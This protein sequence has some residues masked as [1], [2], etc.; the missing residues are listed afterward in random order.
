MDDLIITA[1]KARRPHTGVGILAQHPFVAIDLETTGVSADLN[2]IVEIG[3]VKMTPTGEVVETF[4][5]IV[6]PGAD[7][8]LPRSAERIHHIKPHQIRSAPPIDEVLVS[9][10]HFIGN[11]GVVAHQL[12]FENR[13][14]TA[15]YQRIGANLPA[16]QGLCTLSMARKFLNAK[17]NKLEYLLD[18]L[19]LDGVN[20]H[21]ATDDAYACGTFAAHMISGLNVSD[22]EPL[23]GPVNNSPEDGLA[24]AV[25][26]LK[27]TLG[28]VVISEP[29]HKEPDA[30]TVRSSKSPAPVSAP[31]P[32]GS[33]ASTDPSPQDGTSVELLSSPDVLKEAFGGFSPTD[34]QLSA[35]EAFTEGGTTKLVAVAGAGKTATLLGMARLEELRN[36]DRRG[37]YLAFNRSVAEEAKRKF[38]RTVTAM[39]AHKLAMTQLRN[40]PHG[41]LLAKLGER[42]PWRTTADAIYPA[43]TVVDMHDGR[44]LFSSY[45]IG[46]YALRTVEEFCKTLDTDIG[47]QHMPD[48][49]GITRGSIQ[50]QQLAEAVVP[51]AKRAWSNM[52]DPNS[53]AV[54][55][56]HSCY[57]KL[58]VDSHPR[59]GRDGDYI[60]LDEA[61]DSNPVVARLF[62]GQ[63]HLQR[64]LVGDSNQSIYGFT[65]A[66]DSLSKFDADTV[67]TLSQSWRFGDAIADA[68]NVYLRRLQ[69]PVLVRGNSRIDDAV[70]FSLRDTTAVL[71]RTNGGAI[72]EI[73]RTQTAG[74][75]AALVGDV[76]A[77]L[78]FC[79]AA[80]SLQNGNTPTN[81]QFAVFSTWGQLEEYIE[82]QPGMSDLGTQAKLVND[83][84]VDAIESAL[85]NLVSPA[86]ADRIFTTAHKSKGLEYPKVRIADD[87]ADPEVDNDEKPFPLSP[88]EIRDEQRLAYVALTRAQQ[89][90]NPGQLLSQQHLSVR[91]TAP[92][93]MLL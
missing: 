88:S 32:E 67:V 19:G 56:T 69:S 23:G 47:I 34:E 6:N 74:E 31:S 92:A 76:E 82:H 3:A 42:V 65:G 17:S 93:G 50:E 85:A 27:T 40:T 62:S 48:I 64:I 79:E 15:A 22:L 59:I 29:L 41:P 57:L 81:P 54:Q 44:K 39:T 89:A 11:C 5:H 28:A 70:D 8:P 24:E 61:Q 25:A 53:F 30:A 49:T 68:A 13:F 60:L 18:L 46:R 55:F 35:V 7:V 36:P 43:K 86:R 12:Q 38:P 4:S 84:G 51:C 72:D 66:V 73:I 75:S 21:R 1:R 58:F 9:L 37:L 10:A 83:Y 33:V 77:A 26:V 87:F 52:L 91:R 45:V 14:L 20:S 16:W 71:S 90:L 78:K 80:R 2:R 63:S